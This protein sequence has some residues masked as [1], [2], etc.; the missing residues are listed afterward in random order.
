MSTLAVRNSELVGRSV[1]RRDGRSKVTGVTKFSSDLEVA[2]MLHATT[3]RSPFP[4]ARLVRLDIRDAELLDGVAAVL[5]AQD[6][7]GAN[8][9]GVAAPDQ[10]V[11][12]C[13]RIRR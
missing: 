12:V 4:H 10:P 13:C 9:F 11:L 1:R 2:G 6:I 3:L 8:C 7:P 5:T